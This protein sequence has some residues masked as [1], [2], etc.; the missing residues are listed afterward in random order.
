MILPL[1]RCPLEADAFAPGLT[2]LP[3]E[4]GMALAAAT[5]IANGSGFAHT[6]TRTS[7]DVTSP[8]N[9]NGF[10][11]IKDDEGFKMMKCLARTRYSHSY[12]S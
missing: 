5:T 4:S 10:C 12:L 7:F 2:W 6:Y 9:L 1:Q 8:T 3:V 11:G